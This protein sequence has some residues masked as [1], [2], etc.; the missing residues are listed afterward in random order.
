MDINF[1]LEDPELSPRPREEIRITSLQATP[2]KDG[3][4]VR[5][6][7]EITAFAPADRPSLMLAIIGSDRA[8]LSETTIVEAD[9]YRL[10]ITMHLADA[11][12]SPDDPLELH[13]ALYFEPEKPQHVTSIS[14]SSS[15]SGFFDES[16]H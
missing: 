13:A 4:R 8:V 9:Q 12:T 6:M 5:V 11:P 14:F 1:I 2:E 10:A 3:R 16:G 15:G 7:I